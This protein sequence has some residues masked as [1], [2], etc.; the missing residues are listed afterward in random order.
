MPQTQNQGK[1]AVT[2]TIMATKVKDL[3]KGLYL[4]FDTEY[5]GVKYEITIDLE[6]D[7][8][9]I[10]VVTYSPKSDVMIGNPD[11]EAEVGAIF[12]DAVELIKKYSKR[13]TAAEQ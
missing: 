6:S 11:P 9:E 5:N 7:V 1:D 8:P 10:L 4:S 2:R 3:P 13:E 12:R